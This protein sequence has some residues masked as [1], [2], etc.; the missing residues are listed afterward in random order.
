[1]DVIEL[2]SAIREQRKT[3]V[4]LIKKGSVFVYPT[5]TIYGLGCN[6][7]NP[8]SVQRI[9]GIK[10]TQHPFSVIA[11][12]KEWIMKNMVIRHSEYLDKLPGPYTLILE[13]KAPILKAAS[14]LN[15]LGVRIPAHPFTLVVQEAGVPFVT[16]SANISGHDPIKS[17]AEIDEELKKRI[18]VVI[19]AG[20]LNN[21][22]STIYDLTGEEPKII[23]D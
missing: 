11:P 4:S 12:S 2:L 18:D 9:R 10:W 6:A 19:E 5:D 8:E 20:M 1:M 13:K 23:R 17:T 14:R 7:E 22:P 21:P 3:V 16:T 15:T